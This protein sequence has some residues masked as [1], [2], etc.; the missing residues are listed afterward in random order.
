MNAIKPFVLRGWRLRGRDLDALQPPGQPAP[1]LYVVTTPRGG[2]GREHLFGVHRRNRDDSYTSFVLGFWDKKHADELA[3]G[4]EAYH[5][6]HAR[7]P[8]RDVGELTAMARSCTDAVVAQC[9]RARRVDPALVAVQA[10]ALAELLDRLRG[11]GIV[12]SILTATD[13]EGPFKWRDVHTDEASE[14][15]RAVLERAVDDV[16]RLLPKPP[17]TGRRSPPP[18]LF[19]QFAAASLFKLLVIAE[20]SAALM[21]LPDLL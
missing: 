2:G 6:Q 14:V 16:P 19:V 21:L 20:L 3:E 11:T 1:P 7:F 10:V 5:R 13:G 18:P 4:L 15:V 9:G 17:R 12:V 8:P